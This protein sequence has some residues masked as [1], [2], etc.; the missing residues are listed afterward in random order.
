MKFSRLLLFS[1]LLQAA[2]LPSLAQRFARGADISWSTEMLADGKKFYDSDG[3]ETDINALMRACGMNA[4]RLRVWVEPTL[5]G[6]CGTDD[7]VAKAVA[8]RG[9]GMDVLIDF[10]YYDFFA[11]PSRQSIPAAWT[12]RNLTELASLVREHT[13]EVLTALRTAGVEPRWVQVGNETRS[14]MLYSQYNAAAHNWSDA[15][16]MATGCTLAQKGGSWANFATLSNAGYDAAKAVFP[17]VCCISHLDTQQGEADLNWWFDAFR[18]AGGKCDM[19]GLSHYP[20]GW[21]AMGEG[22]ATTDALARNAALMGLARRLYDAYARPIMIVETGVYCEYVDGGKEVMSDLFSQCRQTNFIN[23]IFYW[24]PEQYNWWKPA[25]YQTIGWGNYNMCAFLHDGRP[26]AIL[27][28][29]QPAPSDA[30]GIRSAELDAQPT[31]RSYDLAGRNATP[32]TKGIIVR[33]G[34]KIWQ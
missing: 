5:G 27:D 31:P 33:A 10:H 19:I 15:Q 3:K 4:I 30:D 25:V 22:Q 34:K 12:G 23:G 21:N 26:S 7:V 17:N 13:T 6:W 20:M 2:A 29:F 24:E 16:N 28:A 18:Q 8:A 14:G 11:D 1:L 32:Q 9:A